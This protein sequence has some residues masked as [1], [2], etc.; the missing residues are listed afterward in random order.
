MSETAAITSRLQVLSIVKIGLSIE[1]TENF[2]R[3]IWD[4][5]HI[6]EKQEKANKLTEQRYV[7]KNRKQSN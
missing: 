6:L 1:Q 4:L 5:Q 2:H 3:E 7:Y